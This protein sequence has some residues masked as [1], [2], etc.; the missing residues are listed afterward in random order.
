MDAGVINQETGMPYMMSTSYQN[1]VKA[2][3][4]DKTEEIWD[5][6]YK[7][8]YSERYFMVDGNGVV[9]I[10][11]MDSDNRGRCIW[12]IEYNSNKG[13]VESTPHAG[14]VSSSGVSLNS[15]PSVLKA[16]RFSALYLRLARRSKHVKNTDVYTDG[17]YALRKVSDENEDP[18]YFYE[19]LTAVGRD[20]YATF[21]GDAVEL[22]N[23]SLPEFLLDSI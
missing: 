14:V 17:R 11:E 21:N 19:E 13:T 18:L 8:R 5:N 12:S 6:G 23:I 1:V 15:V 22:Y 16:A 4:C 7:L 10:G 2:L 3:E 9:R 20:W